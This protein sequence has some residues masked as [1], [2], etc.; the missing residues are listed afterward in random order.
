MR[1]IRLYMFQCGVLK[2]HWHEL[3]LHQRLGEPVH[4]PVPWYLITHPDGHSLVDGGNPAVCAI[5]PRQHWGNDVVD[6]FTPEMTR[7]ELASNS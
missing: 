4:V 7:F 5:D 3:M 6:R 2:Q 1:E